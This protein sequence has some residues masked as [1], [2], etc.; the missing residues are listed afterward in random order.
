MSA[1]RVGG[2]VFVVGVV[3]ATS[4]LAQACGSSSQGAGF[5]SDAGGAADGTT[6]DA[7]TMVLPDGAT[8]CGHPDCD[9]DGYT[10]PADCN[11]FNASINPEAYDFHGDG[12][13]DD[14]DGIVDDG[15]EHCETIPQM[16]PGTPAD[17]ARAADLCAQNSKTNAGTVFDPLLNS[18]WGEVQGLGPGQTLYT[19]QTK[20]SIQTNIVSSFGSNMT[21][22]GQTMVGLAN[23]PWDTATPRNSAALD[24]AGF[25]IDDACGSIPLTG[26]DCASIQDGTPNGLVS[27]QDWAELTMWVKVPSNAHGMSFDFS[28]FST[29]FSEFWDTAFNDGFFVL[30]SSDELTGKNVAYGSDGLA[31]TIN[32]SFFALCPE[33]PG[34]AGLSSDKIAALQVCVGDDGDTSQM[35]FGS[36]HG[37]YYDGAGDTPSNGT[38]FSVDGTHEYVYGGGSAWL[39]STFAVTPGEMIQMRVIVFDTYDG[40]KDSSVLFDNL[41]WQPGTSGG[42][43]T[44][45]PPQ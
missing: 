31:V 37:T 9:G 28:F 22:E 26:L 11:D 30:V 4:A 34:P 32:S 21:R 23:G 7:S 3:A 27:V 29:E 38:A 10:A 13:D 15:I 17:F 6:N 8:F 35:I 42:G 20:P 39:T 24:P 33:A 44:Q 45:R 41:R 14:C 40:L 43:T 25:H 19:S 16:A 1:R 5:A 18:A 12:V 36:I 2:G